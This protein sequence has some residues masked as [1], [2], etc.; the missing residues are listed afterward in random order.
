[1]WRMTPGLNFSVGR[2]ARDVGLRQKRIFESTP[3][4]PCSP[5]PPCDSP[6]LFAP[7]ASA[8]QS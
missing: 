1:M 3:K 2:L 8:R 6:S 5:C 7:W 4:P